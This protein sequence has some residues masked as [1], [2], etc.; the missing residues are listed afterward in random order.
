MAGKADN[1]DEEIDALPIAS[2]A[3]ETTVAHPHA[4]G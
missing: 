3:V 1:P 4:L 2:S